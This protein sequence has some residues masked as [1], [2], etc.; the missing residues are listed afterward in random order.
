M[1]E[2]G[3]EKK[4]GWKEREERRRSGWQKQSKKRA[5]PGKREGLVRRKVI[6]AVSN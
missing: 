4:K 3:K 1:G 5:G 6:E 2:N